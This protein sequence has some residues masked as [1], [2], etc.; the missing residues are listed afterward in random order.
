MSESPSP[1]QSHV[2]LIP[3][4]PRNTVC[5]LSERGGL[6]ARREICGDD[7]GRKDSTF[8]KN[9]VLLRQ[10]STDTLKCE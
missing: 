8:Q 4:S 9:N 6:L 10:T 5:S 3:L 1:H 7:A 2:P